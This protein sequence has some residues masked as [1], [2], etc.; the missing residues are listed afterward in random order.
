VGTEIEIVVE[1]RAEKPDGFEEST[2]RTVSENS[3]T[4]KFEQFRFEEG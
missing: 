1:I 2:I 4:L 3:R